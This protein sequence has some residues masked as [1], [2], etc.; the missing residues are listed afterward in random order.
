MSSPMAWSVAAPHAL[1]TRRISALSALGRVSSALLSRPTT[2]CW[3]PAGSTVAHGLEVQHWLASSNDDLQKAFM[4][5][6][7]PLKI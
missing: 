7:E 6:K 4:I 3:L 1:R 5:R 2:P